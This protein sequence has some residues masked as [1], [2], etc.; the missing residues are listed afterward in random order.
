MEFTHD[1]IEKLLDEVRPYLLADGGDVELVETEGAV[2]K[3]RLRGAC[4]S[5]PNQIITLKSGIEKKLIDTI[6]EI[7]EVR[8]VL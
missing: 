8:L 2:V 3:I 6:P 7:E 1:N 5:C 4:E